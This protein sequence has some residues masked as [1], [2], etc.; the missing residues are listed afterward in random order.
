MSAVFKPKTRDELKALVD[1]LIEE[2]GDNA[3]LNIFAHSN[4]NGDISEWDVSNVTDMNGMFYASKQFD[5]N[6]SKRD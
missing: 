5:I 6:I 4:F 1:K 2:R 3:D